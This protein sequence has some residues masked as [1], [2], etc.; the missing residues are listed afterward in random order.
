MQET[1]QV[2]LKTSQSEFLYDEILQGVD[3]LHFFSNTWQAQDLLVKWVAFE[4][5][6]K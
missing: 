4:A 3:T 2:R 1:E 6:Q 5:K